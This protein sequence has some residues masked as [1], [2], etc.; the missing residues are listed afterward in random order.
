MRIRCSAR[1]VLQV[2]DLFDSLSDEGRRAWVIFR[3]VGLSLEF[4]I[5]DCL[6]TEFVRSLDVTWNL[7]ILLSA[8]GSVLFTAITAHSLFKHLTSSSSPLSF[9]TI[10]YLRSNFCHHSPSPVMQPQQN[11]SHRPPTFHNH[12]RSR[13]T[14]LAD[15]FAPHSPPPSDPFAP[16]SSFPKPPP[17]NTSNSTPATSFGAFGTSPPDPFAQPFGGSA[18]SSSAPGKFGATGSVPF[19]AQQSAG[20]FGSTSLPPKF[21]PSSQPTNFGSSAHAFSSVQSKRPVFGDEQHN[22]PFNPPPGAAASDPFA[23]PSS[24]PKDPFAPATERVGRSAGGTFAASGGAP[25]DPFAPRG[26]PGDRP[27]RVLAKQLLIRGVPPSLFSEGALLWHFASIPDV[28]PLGATLRGSMKGPEGKR[29]ALVSFAT[30]QEASIAMSRAR[31]HKGVA[32]NMSYYKGASHASVGNGDRMDMQRPPPPQVPESRELVFSYVPEDLFSEDAV[33]NLFNSISG[34]EVVAV[35]IRSRPYRGGVKR[36]A[37]VTFSGIAAARNALQNLPSYNGEKLRVSYR[38][39]PHSSGRSS[40]AAG[41]SAMQEVAMESADDQNG[42]QGDDADTDGQDI[43]AEGGQED[44]GEEVD[45]EQAEMEAARQ[46]EIEQLRRDI[47]R[48]EREVE[49]IKR[50]STTRTK[51]KGNGQKNGGGNVKAAYRTRSDGQTKRHAS[52]IVVR[53]GTND[54]GV[55]RRVGEKIDINNAVQFVGTCQTMCPEKELEER[56]LQR[57]I[58]IFE[59]VD[60]KGGEPDRSRA[61]KKYRRSAAISEEPTPEEV[62]PPPV[63]LRT[64]EYLKGICDSKDATFI[65]IHNFVRDRT[66]SLRQD[67]TYQGIRDDVCIKIHEES[68]RFHILSEHRLSGANPAVFS[69]KQNREQL[70]KCLISLR[71]MYDLRRERNLPTSPNE[72]EMQSYY[73]LMQM[74]EL[75][76]CVQLFAGFAEDVRNS[77]PVQFALQVLKANSNSFTNYVRYFACKRAAP[78]LT[79]CLMRS[80]FHKIRCAA[81]DIINSTHGSPT[82]RDIIAIS[83][84]THQLGFESEEETIK[85]CSTAGFDIVDIERS[86]ENSLGKALSTPSPDVDFDRCAELLPQKPDFFIEN[87]TKGL[88]ISN[89][90]EGDSK[91][92][93]DW[94]QNGDLRPSHPNDKNPDTSFAEGPTPTTV[95]PFSISSASSQLSPRVSPTSKS[96]PRTVGNTGEGNDGGRLQSVFDRLS[97]LA[98][99]PSP[100]SMFP[101]FPKTE[102]APKKPV[103]PNSTLP[104]PSSL[105][106]FQ[107]TS[108]PVSTVDVPTKMSVT[109]VPTSTSIEKPSDLRL[110]PSKKRV[111]FQDRANDIQQEPVPPQVVPASLLK[112]SM[113]GFSS[114]KSTN[115]ECR[116]GENMTPNALSGSVPSKEASKE[117]DKEASKEAISTV[118]RLKK[119]EAEKTQEQAAAIRRQR[120]KEIELTRQ[121]SKRGKA[122]LEGHERFV[123]LVE[124]VSSEMGIMEQRLKIVQHR[125]ESISIENFGREKVHEAC[126]D[127]EATFEGVSKELRESLARVEAC[128]PDTENGIKLKDGL[129]HRLKELRSYGD[130][131]WR[132]VWRMKGAV[133]ITPLHTPVFLPR[134]KDYSTVAKPSKLKRKANNSN[135]LL[136][137]NSGEHDEFGELM[138]GT[139]KAA[140]L[141]RTVT[142]PKFEEEVLISEMRRQRMVRLHIDVVDGAVGGDDARARTLSWLW[143]RL[144]RSAECHHAAIKIIKKDAYVSIIHRA[145]GIGQAMNELYSDVILFIV[146]VSSKDEFKKDCQRILEMLSKRRTNENSRGFGAPFIILLLCMNKNALEGGNG[147]VKAAEVKKFECALTTCKF[148]CGCYAIEIGKK[149]VTFGG[150]SEELCV[151]LRK[152]VMG[153]MKEL[154]RL[155]VAVHS[156]QVGERAV[157]M[158]TSAWVM[159]LSSAKHEVM[160]KGTFHDV[161]NGVNASWSTILNQM[162]EDETRW[163]EGMTWEVERLRELR[164]RLSK[165]LKLPLP[166]ELCAADAVEYIG[167]I[168]RLANVARPKIDDVEGMSVALFCRSLGHLMTP[169]VSTTLSSDY[170]ATVYLPDSSLESQESASLYWLGHHLGNMGSKGMTPSEVIDRAWDGTAIGTEPLA[171]SKV[172]AQG[173]IMRHG[174]IGREDVESKRMFGVEREGAGIGATK[175]GRVSLEFL[176]CKLE[177]TPRA[178]RRRHSAPEGTVGVREMYRFYDELCQVEEMHQG[179][180]DATIDMIQQERT[181]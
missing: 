17:F 108:L 102:N 94:S 65:D 9:G 71:E 176:R 100:K 81:L 24:T 7:L 99:K 164:I 130:Q 21:G 61:V 77:V 167:K 148:A 153:S 134:E 46:A 105:G 39:K 16:N 15:P 35:S 64:M 124:D 2:S 26:P 12:T 29:T 70:D 177:F 87:K 160:G 23:P 156:C 5:P 90:I 79:A 18:F 136:R 48:K 131:V 154:K 11:N 10:S 101:K 52:K 41:S 20:A 116:E 157:E 143:G 152:A 63:L 110:R 75:Q 78:Y 112:S 129:V 62:R 146:D 30:P 171:L 76:T 163:A 56:I 45:D 180:L 60:G 179:L 38:S 34:N 158:G 95:A 89:I 91:D 36:T 50:Q 54:N 47:E 53:E 93:F 59:T 44:Y 84:L 8:F 42:E 114:L 144:N 33:R 120:E 138:D 31:L 165:K 119:L 107:Y 43:D 166:S 140:K 175:T 73:I 169:F 97:P 4:Q 121:Q 128:S 178:R 88:A 161:I 173:Q 137:R 113:L 133:I 155:G 37:I 58:S 72:P 109:L 123:K 67:F 74:S 168:A 55:W 25:G 14:L 6:L 49:R 135:I 96:S 3:S 181:D 174:L 145:Y 127:A 92:Q 126:R 162:E 28:A 85:F 141:R 103:N 172:K 66:R 159:Y 104:T 115:S 1:I 111:R 118:A 117:A 86:A 170:F 27:P 98:S 122:R 57:D 139:V 83:T 40:L 149:T 69:S 106:S 80:R 125:F 51:S 151:G 19:G 68:V 82:S 142:G 150:A 22:D 147:V 32:L 132:M 13:T